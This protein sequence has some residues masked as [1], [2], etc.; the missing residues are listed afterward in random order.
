MKYWLLLIALAITLL[1]PTPSLLAS[2]SKPIIPDYDIVVDNRKL[3]L[4]SPPFLDNGT[5]MVPFRPIFGKLGLEVTWD[6]GTQRISATDAETIIEMQIGSK[7]AIV[8]G[9]EVELSLP[10]MLSQGTAYVPLRFVGTAS[11]GYVEL[12]PGGLNVVWIMSAKQVQLLESVL[13]ENVERAAP[14]L[15]AG[16][17]PMV[18]VGP[19]GPPIYSLASGSVGMVKLFLDHGMGI[20]DYTEDAFIGTTLLQDAASGGHV[21]TVEYLLAAGADPL[22]TAGAGWTPLE[23][24]V[25]GKESL[26]QGFYA[27]YPDTWDIPTVEAYEKIIALLQNATVSPT[28]NLPETADDAK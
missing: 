1:S 22:E 4:E 12:F 24:A 16:A 3:E 14:L 20:N 9:A 13:D 15:A 19:M 18:M 21:E 23:F 17:D 27:D 28:P 7:T 6:A 8:N 11:G 25:H 10:P 5:T 26:E 2:G